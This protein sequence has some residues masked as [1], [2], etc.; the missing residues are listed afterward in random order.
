MN[1][2]LKQAS[3][4]AKLFNS[5]EVLL[6]CIQHVSQALFG[7]ES[8]DYSHLQQLQKA[9]LLNGSVFC[10]EWEPFSNLWVVA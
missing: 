2:R 10:K 9:R 7:Q 6:L 1:E 8:S 4:Q 5:R 3:G